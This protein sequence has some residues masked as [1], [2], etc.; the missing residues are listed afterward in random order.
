MS[1]SLV[2]FEFSVLFFGM[3]AISEIARFQIGRGS[4][5]LSVSYQAVAPASIEKSDPV[6]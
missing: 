4:Q 6:T 2:I 3:K 5:G 1:T